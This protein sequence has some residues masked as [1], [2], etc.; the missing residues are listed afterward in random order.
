[1]AKQTEPLADEAVMF[2]R[3]NIAYKGSAVTRGTGRGVVFATGLHTE[4]GKIFEQVSEARPQR[5][6]L[7]KRLDALG[8]RLAWAVIIIGIALALVGV[9]MGRDIVLALEVAI[10]LAV[11]AIPE[12][13]PIVATIALARGMWR[14]AQRNALVTRLSA[15]E[16]LGA[17]S[18]ILTDKTG[19]LT[20]NRMTA[21][22]VLVDGDA[23]ELS[24]PGAG[25][26][27]KLLES[28]LATAALC[29]GASLQRSEAAGAKAVGDPTECA[30]LEAAATRGIWQED[31][32]AS[33]PEVFED[34][35]DPDRKRMAT[36]HAAGTR[37][38]VA[39]KGAPEVVIA[40]C[41]TVNT[42]DGV[43]P[44]D[45]HH[46]QD[47][48]ARVEHLC[49]EGLRTI[50]VAEKD[51]DSRET[52]FYDGL[53]LM[54]VFGIEDPP[55]A[56]IED[57]IR[58][59][60]DAGV[61][62][63][64]VTG[65][66]A[67]TARNVAGD[68]GII[69]DSIESQQLLGGD[70]VDGLFDDERHEALLDARVFSRVTPEQKLRLI[71]L[72]Q[73]RG[74]V[75]AMTG[76]GVNDAPALR[77]ADIGVAMGLRGTAV[78]REASE[79]VLQDDELG[80]IVS[81]IEH[82]RVIFENIR[83]FAVYLLSCNSSEILVVTLATVVGAPLPL[84]PLQILFLNLVT[85]VFPALAL[86]V[87]P[88]RPG[89]MK[90]K[91]RPSDENILP[92]RD[93]VRIGLH[94]LVMAAATLG[95]MAY[96][97]LVL[98]FDVQRAVSVAFCTIALAQLWHVFNMRGDIRRVFDNEITRNPWIWAALALCLALV[99]M[100]VYVPVLSDVLQLED[101]GVTGWLVIATASMA[102]LLAAPLVRRWAR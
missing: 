37:F 44:L 52:D 84:L 32:L 17:T 80:T 2:E 42:S 81:A 15:V 3:Y 69:G 83:K 47:W 64:M 1:V 13:L 54:G 71:D 88:G 35:F 9:F 26:K 67:D 45:E 31:L 94:G 34:P 61:E 100:A 57:V 53:T 11:A 10:A 85:D 77:K 41:N 38:K 46:R 96:A 92:R 40:S 99:L 5:T 90:M 59:C 27:T 36:V 79:M 22:T 50:A 30:L 48:L 74:H 97:V 63:V 73:R 89:L 66:H 39:V 60:R 28:L 14:M 6:P 24:A 55:R 20:E 4:F 72:Y 8:K 58:K 65:D 93:W 56:G 62:V 75:V 43:V 21:T 76:D 23:L 70:V 7:E 87:G 33:T 18:V 86:G 101:P 98:E 78:A 95:A 68:I 12:G 25:G 29:N 82:G 102:P 16:T 49:A 19:T 91:P 51:A